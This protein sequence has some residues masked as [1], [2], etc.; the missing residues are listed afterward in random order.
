M[1]KILYHGSSYPEEHYMVDLSGRLAEIK[2]NRQRTKFL[3]IILS[4]NI[5]RININSFLEG[6]FN[7]NK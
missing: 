6:A 5:S 3:L 2:N 1:D 4:I 7:K